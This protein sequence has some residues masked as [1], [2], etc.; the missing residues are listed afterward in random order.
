MTILE[1]LWSN[2][3]HW[4]RRNLVQQSSHAEVLQ[5]VDESAK[6]APRYAFM[7]LM[8]CGIATLGLLQNSAA[9]IIGAML[10][11]PLM[12]PIIQLGIS[13]TTFDW[14]RARRALL[15]LLAGVGL[16]LALAIAIVWMSP[17]KELTPE[18]LVRTEPTL[19]DL[20]VAVFSGFAG[21]Y[22]TITRK[23]ET[24]VGVAIATALMPPLAVTGIGL[25]LGNAHVAGGAAF[26][27]MTNLL[28]ISLSATIMGRIYGFAG[29]DTPHQSALQAMLIVATF[30]LLSIPL[31]LALRKIAVRAHVE[32]SVRKALDE[33]ATSVSGRIDTVRVDA[34][35]QPLLV[36]AV[37]MAPHH[38]P[39]VEARLRQSLRTTLKRDVTL[40]LREVLTTNDAAQTR[41][42]A[43]LAELRRNV[44]ALRG[45][46]D[47]TR[48]GETA[49]QTRANASRDLLLASVGTIESDASGNPVRF[50]V[51]ADSD[52]GLAGSQAMERAMRRGNPDSAFA[53]IPPLQPLLPIVFEADSQDMSPDATRDATTDA[54]A[55]SR[56]AASGVR[57]ESHAASNGA[58]RASARAGTVSDLLHQ[59]G[60]RVTGM[61]TVLA[62]TLH[63][64]R[65]IAVPEFVE[66]WVERAGAGEGAL[67]PP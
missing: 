4:R 64:R 65:S 13:L 28:A 14:A 9:V 1:T 23:G 52:I 53:V 55:L 58:K 33:A 50:R 21:A 5:H 15:A 36:D 59:Q 17:L 27:F 38:A 37:L 29:R 60:I 46:A 51:R 62:K 42:Q 40:H 41:E 12:G 44:D 39:G 7:T 18:I 16:T 24:I 34:T 63:G 3:L 25:A 10:I 66:L 22:A 56:W 30:L 8:S 47:A 61:D 45:A 6:L 35:V 49:I 43:A 57:I 19:F 2:L 11:S 26:L 54:W 48:L 31:G 32:G 67:P 20:L